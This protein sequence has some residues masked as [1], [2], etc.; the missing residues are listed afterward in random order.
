MP[1][2]LFE[3]CVLFYRSDVERDRLLTRQC[4]PGYLVYA[5]IACVN[6]VA[7]N[8]QLSKNKIK[9]SL[10]K[11]LTSRLRFKKSPNLNA[12]ED[13]FIFLYEHCVH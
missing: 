1:S 11:Y 4:E 8:I 5:Q 13:K 7:L 3:T 12:I 6:W 2:E 9:D 10:S